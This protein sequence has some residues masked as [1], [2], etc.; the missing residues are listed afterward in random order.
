MVDKVFKSKNLTLYYTDSLNWAKRSEFNNLMKYFETMLPI[1]GKFMKGKGASELSLNSHIEVQLTLCGD[2]RIRSLNK[3][4]RKKDKATDV[5]SFPIHDSLRRDQRDEA[6]LFNM[7]NI[8]DIVI[9]RD[10]A[11][12]QAKHFEIGLAEEIVHLFIH[13]FL[14]LCGFDHELSKKEHEIMFGLEQSL[15]AKAYKKLGLKG[16]VYSYGTDS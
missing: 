9:S 3:L 14:H 11:R 1:L 5:L 10:T 8:G 4:Y 6:F 7:I 15:V 2:K 16:K 13:G 12:K